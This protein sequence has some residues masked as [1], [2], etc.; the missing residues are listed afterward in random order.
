MARH[1]IDVGGGKPW[2]EI[3]S[4]GRSGLGRRDRLSS[5]QIES[6]R[7]TVGRTPE[8]MVKMLNRGG[9]GTGAVARHL[10][11]LDRDGDLPIHTD[12]GEELVGSK[13]PARLIDD[14]D[15]DL[16]ENR[17]ATAD[18]KPRAPRGAEP[19]KLVHK[20]LF[21]MPAETPPKKVQEGV[22]NFVRDEFGAKH[23]YAIV[24]HTDEP[25]PHVHLVVKT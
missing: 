21:S 9:Q 4:Y 11:Y 22:K 12:L 16:E 15:L 3:G 14:W 19:P 1:R 10:N 18:H 5:A 23:R 20:I 25:R 7:R 2:L 17:P 6:I 24:L 8:V 13:A